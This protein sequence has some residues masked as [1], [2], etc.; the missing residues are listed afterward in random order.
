VKFSHLESAALSD[1]GRKRKRNEDAFVT[2]PDLGVY[3]VADGMGGVSGGD[4]AS[5]CIQETVTQIFQTADKQAVASFRGRT[6]LYVQAIEAASS[7]IKHYA[8]EKG[9]Q[10][11]GS[12]VLA[13]LFDQRDVHRALALHAGDSRLYRL[14]GAELTQ[15]TR[16][17]T[18]A[19][20]LGRSEQSLP[21]GF[22]NRLTKA[23]GLAE[24]ADLEKTAVEVRSGDL[25]L[26]CS[27]G[28]S[29]MV[30]ERQLLKTLR[31]GLASD[32]K[33]LGDE[34]IRQANAAG[35]DDNITL[36]LVRVGVLDGLEVE[37]GSDPETKTPDTACEAPTMMPEAPVI[38]AAPPVQRFTDTATVEGVTPCTP[39]TPYT[40]SEV[41]VAVTQEPLVEPTLAPPPN[42]AHLVLPVPST[43]TAKVIVPQKSVPP[44]IRRPAKEAEDDATA[45]RALRRIKT[46]K[47]ISLIA[48][49]LVIGVGGVVCYRLNPA[50]PAKK[51]ASGTTETG[52]TLSA[53]PKPSAG[54]V[55]LASVA[56]LPDTTT[57][58][59]VSKPD[60]AMSSR[61]TAQLPAKSTDNGLDTK[62]PAPLMQTSADTRTPATAKPPDSV[63]I[64]A[65][66]PKPALAT[67]VIVAEP[68]DRSATKAP[69]VTSVVPDVVTSPIVAIKKPEQILSLNAQNAQALRRAEQLRFLEAFSS[70]VASAAKSGRWGDLSNRVS[71]QNLTE[72]QLR[73]R[74]DG[75]YAV[76][77]A[78]LKTWRQ[79][80][81]NVAM[82]QQALQ[83]FTWQTAM[84]LNGMG[85]PIPLE[86]VVTPSTPK[87][88]DSLC[89]DLFVA[90]TAWL[91]VV[92]QYMARAYAENK[93]WGVEAE[94]LYGL[95]RFTGKH[96]ER[97]NRVVRAIHQIDENLRKVHGL[98]PKDQRN[99]IA[100]SV[101]DEV[102]NRLEQV[103]PQRL[104][105]WAEVWGRIQ[106]IPRLVAYAQPG[107]KEREDALA[108]LNERV[109]KLASI[110]KSDAEAW[111][112]KANLSDVGDILATV[113]E[114]NDIPPADEGVAH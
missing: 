30:S 18:V 114:I 50:P 23:V 88:A 17:H 86:Y 31:Q 112:G 85:G 42:S 108:K 63:I 34:L 16:D 91:S 62:V 43:E 80:S 60:A 103:Q 35:G 37:P 100:A 4:V 93:T 19:A 68:P 27:D 1:Q 40:P 89:H 82:A 39:A 10:D 11:M 72:Q 95:W 87:L 36:V 61:P 12:T 44:D 41:P 65:P 38:V 96:E 13:L 48:V 20:A 98:V 78:W 26:L 21:V 58:P 111:A 64:A 15:I 24:T 2:L 55:P 46:K 14:R 90:Q 107:A 105:I 75:S 6:S 70:H 99:V 110:F 9:S 79:A 33:A 8:E 29:R 84:I 22:R 73:E 102:F 52:I 66:P 53:L 69:S 101:A 51:I 76:Y 92:T 106:K 45:F 5:R 81:T 109:N 7:W 54:T 67:A 83:R 59:P 104:I 57:R 56:F 28:L 77:E 113:S 3:C 97:R 49:G 47:A 25:Y 74:D 94:R 71:S 32:L